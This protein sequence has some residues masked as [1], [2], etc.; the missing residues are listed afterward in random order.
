[1]NRSLKVMKVKPSSTQRS[2][3]YV[4]VKHKFATT[5]NI[6]S[7]Q[8]DND[9]DRKTHHSNDNLV[10][11]FRDEI[12]LLKQ[13]LNQNEEILVSMLNPERKN[14][15]FLKNDHTYYQ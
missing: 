8:S 14:G 1:M 15:E 10:S 3:R 11:Q 6:E 7:V 9:F 13:Q 5:P 2:V 12:K 4:R